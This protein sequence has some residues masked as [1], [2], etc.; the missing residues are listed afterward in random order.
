MDIIE[1]WANHDEMMQPTFSEYMDDVEMPEAPIN[2]WREK[3]KSCRFD[4]WDCNY[5]ES[6]LES[7]LKKQKRKEMN[8]LVDLAIRSIDAAVDNKSNFNPKGYDVLGLSSNKVR[9]LLNNLCQERGTV[10]VDAGSYMGSTVFAALYGNSA[11]KAYAIDDFQDEVV[12]PK[13]KDLHK[14]YED[15]TNPV[16]EFIKNAEKWMNTDCSIGFSVKPIQAV[17]F[18]PKYP[19]RVIFYDAAN[20]HDMIPNLEHIHKHADKDYILVVDDANF[21]GVMDKT[22]EFTKDKNIIW[23]RTILTETSEDA[24]DFWN[25]VH[26]AVIEK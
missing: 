23:E 10:Y 20:D 8:P 6:V 21:E 2:I 25:G 16:D 7:R 22:K 24:N 3:I 18:N 4:C 12:K 9:H 26:L 15:I 19:P 17:E 1:R 11:V 5:C 13:R 14:P